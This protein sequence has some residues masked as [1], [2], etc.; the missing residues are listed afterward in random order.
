MPGVCRPSPYDR[1]SAEPPSYVRF[2][3]QGSKNQP[4]RDHRLLHARRSSSG[5]CRTKAA[6]R[7]LK[8]R[9]KALVHRFGALDRIHLPL[10]LRSD[11]RPRLLQSALYSD[12]EGLRAHPGIHNALDPGAKRTCRALLPS[13]E[14]RMHLAALVRITG[15]GPS[16]DRLLDQVIQRRAATSAIELCAT[17]STPVTSRIG[18]AKTRGSLQLE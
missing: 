1:M 4:G 15:P 2:V 11:K 6:A 18:Y 13:L 3:R 16:G 8:R 17:L 5:D 12:C 9:W 14:A 10:A 7:R